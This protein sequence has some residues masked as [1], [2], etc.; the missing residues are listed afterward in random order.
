MGAR[1]TGLDISAFSLD[2]SDLL[3]TLTSVSIAINGVEVNG[4]GIADQ[5]VTAI[6]AGGK[7]TITAKL[8]H[9]TSGAASTNLNVTAWSVGGT[10][11]VGDLRSGSIKI[12]NP[13]TEVKGISDKWSYPQAVGGRSME[14]SGQLMVPAATVLNALMTKASSATVSDHTL[15]FTSTIGGDTFAVDTI[16]LNATHSAERGEVQQLDVQLKSSGTPS[17]TGS[18]IYTVAIT[19]DALLSI[20]LDTEAGQYGTGGAALVAL[21]TSMD[22]TFSDGAVVEVSLTLEVQGQPTVTASS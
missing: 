15:A 14:I 22:I 19:G 3:A 16:L 2:G 11:Y 7:G 13:S 4:S 8:N 21:V 1:K 9:Q 20:V 12:T 17:G 18:G 10:S 6:W 5:F